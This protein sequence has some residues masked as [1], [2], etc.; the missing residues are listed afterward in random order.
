MTSLGIFKS[1]LGLLEH[2][3]VKTVLY[4]VLA[5]E[6]ITHNLY[7]NIIIIV[8]FSNCYR[9][10][11]VIT[12]IRK[13]VLRKI[14]YNYSSTITFASTKYYSFIKKNRNDFANRYILAF[15]YI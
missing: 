3:E 5:I 2:Y 14:G 8:L 4:F 9:L 1:Q 12:N 11:I 13:V 6:E 15:I 10:F 7:N